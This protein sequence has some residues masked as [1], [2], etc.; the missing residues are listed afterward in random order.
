MRNLLCRGS[1]SAQGLVATLVRSILAQP[2]AAST[3]AQHACIVEQLTER[4]PKRLSCWLIR[5]AT[6][7]P[8]RRSQGS[9]GARVGRTIPRSG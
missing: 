1:K 5:P 7:W 4:F 9:T 8:S 6:C 2:D 3:Q